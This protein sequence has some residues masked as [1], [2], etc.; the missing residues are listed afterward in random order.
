MKRKKNGK[1]KT[2]ALDLNYVHEEDLL[3][4]YSGAMATLR[5]LR[6]TPL[7]IRHPTSLALVLL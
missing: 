4:Q 5:N 6:S 1:E 7:S 2:K 3:L